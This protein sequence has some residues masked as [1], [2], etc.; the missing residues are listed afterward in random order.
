MP[1]TTRFPDPPPSSMKT[2]LGSTNAV[3]AS[4][5]VT[6]CLARLETALASSHSKSPETT[7]GTRGIWHRTHMVSK[8]CPFGLE[9]SSPDGAPHRP[10]SPPQRRYLE[11]VVVRELSE[12]AVPS[13]SIAHAETIKRKES[14]CGAG[15]GIRTRDHKL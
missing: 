5:K 11:S 3:T 1:M 12:A 4:S 6:P 10:R 2:A 9:R 7:V 15:H 8:P 14:K 13:L